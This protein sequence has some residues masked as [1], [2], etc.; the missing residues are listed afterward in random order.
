MYRSAQTLFNQGKIEEGRRHLSLL[1]RVH[2]K[3]RW[4][5][6]GHVAW[7]R[8]AEARGEWSEAVEHLDDPGIQALAPKRRAQAALAAGDALAMLDRFADARTRAATALESATTA[9]DQT[10]RREAR[11]LSARLEILGL[12]APPPR[13]AAAIQEPE[14]SL[15]PPLSLGSVA[16]ASAPGQASVST[17][18][19]LPIPAGHVVWLDF[20][21]TNC[22]HCEKTYPQVRTQSEEAVDNGVAVAWIGYDDSADPKSPPDLEPYRAY[23]RRYP[24]PGLVAVDFAHIATFAMFQG[25]GSPW[26]VLIDRKGLVRYCDVYNEVKVRDKLTQLLSE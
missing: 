5:A 4:A 15:F 6:E 17:P 21:Q 24:R 9:D 23:I 3:T 2:P 7:G 22:P 11:T 10:L 14:I 20:F 25:R 18:L 19:D 13:V 12:P 8:Q 1:F 16:P 26:T